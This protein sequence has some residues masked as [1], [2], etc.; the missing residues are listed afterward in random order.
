MVA[1]DQE[2]IDEAADKVDLS[3]GDA[4]LPERDKDRDGRRGA[5]R[6]DLRQGHRSRLVA[7][8]AKNKRVGEREKREILWRTG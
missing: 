8:G 7:S 6:G 2:Q 1:V 4:S 5:A 3:D